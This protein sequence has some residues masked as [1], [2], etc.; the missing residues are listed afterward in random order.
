MG[1][2]IQL[3]RSHSHRLMPAVTALL[4]L[5]AGIRVLCDSA[6]VSAESHWLPQMVLQVE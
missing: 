2:R 1:A 3:E 4:V 6:R 5:G